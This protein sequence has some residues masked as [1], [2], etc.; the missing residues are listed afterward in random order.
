MRLHLVRHGR[1]ARVAGLPA[2]TWRLDADDPGI[3]RLGAAELLTGRA[4]WCSSPEPKALDTARAMAGA[5]VPVAVVDDLAEMRRPASQL[6]ADEFA[7]AV[8][9]AFDH[10][11]EAALAGW[12]TATSTRARVR[13][14]IERECAASLPG[15][16]GGT[17]GG[18]AGD[19]VAIGHGTAWTLL[20]ADLT[21]TPVD[22][23]GWTRMVLPDLCVL[24]LDLDRSDG[25]P[26]RLRGHLVRG[27][28]TVP[29]N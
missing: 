8:R 1:P 5:E 19:V 7:A 9:R 27:W 10:P 21:A 20:V 22:V 28:G 26:G 29:G 17:G 2:S 16:D 14:A 12:E 13:A 25:L 24:D 18:A 11:D 6:G 23:D 4:R 15:T 3:V